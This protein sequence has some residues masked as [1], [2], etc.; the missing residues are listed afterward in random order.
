MATVHSKLK[1]I[2]DADADPGA[3]VDIMLCGY[4]SRAP[5]AR[6]T[7]S[8][9]ASFYTAESLS[10][11]VTLPGNAFTVTLTGNDL[12]VPAG[13]YYTVTFRD[14]NGDILQCNAYLFLGGNDYDLTNTDPFD[15]TQPLPPLPPL[16]INQL[17]S[18]ANAAAF[19]FDGSTYLS[20]KATL[21]Q[22]ATIQV[23]NPQPGNLYTVIIVQDG[24]GGHTVGWNAQFIN[25]TAINLAPN[26]MTVQTF[27]CDDAG[28]LDSI[29]GAT[30][31]T[32]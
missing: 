2:G 14:P 1:G 5:V 25:S 20:F 8:E 26:G 11:G 29:S 28:N 15:P 10:I 24:V 18:A 23:A 32:P 9:A 6:G 22:N 3:T 12:I 19:D 4:G 16:I 30:W 31:W 21:N 27:I 7:G 17:Q 13:T